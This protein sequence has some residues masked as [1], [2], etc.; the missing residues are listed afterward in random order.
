MLDPAEGLSVI[1]TDLKF[2]IALQIM[3]KQEPPYE[4]YDGDRRLQLESIC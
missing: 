2:L 1:A 3:Q 4:V